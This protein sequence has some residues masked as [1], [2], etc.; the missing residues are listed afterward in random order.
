[1]PTSSPAGF[2]IQGIWLEGVDPPRFQIGNG[3]QGYTPFGVADWNGANP[4]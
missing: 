3:L 1:V 4:R 2:A